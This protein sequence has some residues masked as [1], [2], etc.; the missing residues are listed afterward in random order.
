MRLVSLSLYIER[1][2]LGPVL[3]L[4]N[5]EKAFGALAAVAPTS[6]TIDQGSFVSIVGPSGCGKS[7]LFNMIAGLEAPSAGLVQLH[8]A[9]ISGRTGHVGYMLQKDL[10]APWRTVL[11][12]ITMG[13]HLTRGVTREDEERGASL[14]HQY[15]L[16]EF[17]A[18]YPEALSGG[19]RQR[20]ALMRTLMTDHELLLLDEPF[21]ALD[22]QTR[23][24]MQRWL[25]EVW[26]S[27]QRTVLFVTHDVDEAIFLSDRI[28]VMSERP[29]RIVLDL[30]IDLPRP[31]RTAMLTDVAFMG[32]KREILSLLH[33]EAGE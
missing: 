10:L 27:T 22:A 32:A 1:V 14:A 5:T 19:M 15:G 4:A 2:D 13:A 21:G 31:R 24:E 20:V 18:H 6:F 30:P 28:L 9:D 25:L 33:Y 7:T 11:G 8:G 3:T 23:F 16:G 12:N 26:Q 29:G 17:L